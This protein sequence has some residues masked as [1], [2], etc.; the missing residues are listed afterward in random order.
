MTLD[1]HA[2]DDALELPR[3]LAA[4]RAHSAELVVVTAGDDGQ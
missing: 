2:A 1:L 4:E 3:E